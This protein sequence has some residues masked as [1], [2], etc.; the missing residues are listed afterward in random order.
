MTNERTRSM[1]SAKP[2]PEVQAFRIEFINLFRKHSPNIKPVEI[3][4]VLSHTVGQV[5]ALQNINDGTLADYMT[6]IQE[7]IERGNSEAIISAI[8]M[9]VKGNA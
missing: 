6:V 8:K 5:L 2:S 4:A 3:L 7:N 9:Q 1:K